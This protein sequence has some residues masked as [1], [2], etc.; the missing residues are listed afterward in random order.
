M[1]LG[2]FL[3]LYIFLVPLPSRHTH[4]GHQDFHQPHFPQNQVFVSMVWLLVDSHFQM[5]HSPLNLAHLVHL[6]RLVQLQALFPPHFVLNF[7][8]VVLDFSHFTFE[9]L[10]LQVPILC[11]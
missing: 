5:D 4:I 10:L 6:A 2:C 3:D 8:L 1:R 11:L 7:H 9:E